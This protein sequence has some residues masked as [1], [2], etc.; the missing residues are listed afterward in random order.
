VPQAFWATVLP[1]VRREHPQAYFVGEVIHGDYAAIVRDS[2]LDAVTQYEVWKA[3]WSS[4]NDRNLFELSWALDR[5]NGYLAGFVPLTFVG[6]H[7]VTRIASRLVD[8][9]YLP[10]ALAV[11]FTIGG[12]PSVY[13]GDEQ[14]FR[15]IKEHR[16]GGDDAVRP[17]FPAG[18]PDLL[19][20]YGWPTYRLH[21]DLIGLRRRHPWLHAARTEKRELTNTRFV[22]E[23]ADGPHRI[24]VVLS[25]D[26]QPGTHRVP[27][28]ARVLAGTGRLAGSGSGARVEVPPH[29]WAIVG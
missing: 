2:G 13:Y 16:A 19:A 4:L 14:A 24:M 6:N 22:Y 7:D 26:D 18:G 5:H 12:T 8:D 17:V 28:V 3:I 15:G 27:G 10:H 21:Q 1:R 11:L 23:L 25:L 29:G 9:R 20:P